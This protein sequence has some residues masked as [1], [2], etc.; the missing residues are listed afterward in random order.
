M[1]FCAYVED[2]ENPFEHKVYCKCIKVTAYTFLIS[3][4]GVIF[5]P[6]TKQLYLMYGIGTTIDYLKSN[7]TANQIPDKA[8]KALDAWLDM[9]MQEKEKE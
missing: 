5:I 7:D 2:D 8:I 9:E 3:L 4:L 1:G 6:S